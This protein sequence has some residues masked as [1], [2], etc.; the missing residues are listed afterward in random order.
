[1]V[2]RLGLFE[3]LLPHKLNGRSGAKCRGKGLRGLLAA[4]HS[5]DGL[6]GCISPATH[7]YVDYASRDQS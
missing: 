2:W 4:D 1:M 3:G 6:S 7:L 5:Q